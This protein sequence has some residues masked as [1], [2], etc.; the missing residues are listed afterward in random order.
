M[1]LPRLHNHQLLRRLMAMKHNLPQ[2][3]ATQP[4][5]GIEAR[6]RH[7]DDALGMDNHMP[8]ADAILMMLIARASRTFNE[9]LTCGSIGRC[10]SSTAIKLISTLRRTSLDGR[11]KGVV[12]S[13]QISPR[14]DVA[15]QVLTK[16][17]CFPHVIRSDGGAFCMWLTLATAHSNT[18]PATSLA[19]WTKYPNAQRHLVARIPM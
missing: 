16:H 18:R 6:G 19:T 8:Q 17:H 3:R 7:N 12:L 15:L 4:P 14:R 9:R 11:R 5:R 10:K 2:R 1:A 13:E